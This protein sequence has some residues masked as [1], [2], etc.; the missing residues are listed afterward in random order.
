[1]WEELSSC[2]SVEWSEV[3]VIGSEWEDGNLVEHEC[4]PNRLNNEGEA[5]EI[6]WKI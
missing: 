6:E 3:H 5:V 1:M 2:C 4:G